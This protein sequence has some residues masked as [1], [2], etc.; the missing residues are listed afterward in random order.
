ME[1]HGKAHAHELCTDGPYFLAVCLAE[2]EM[3]EM[4]ERTFDQFE[5]AC[6]RL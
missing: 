4:D 1:P 2:C 5:G 3:L 6:F